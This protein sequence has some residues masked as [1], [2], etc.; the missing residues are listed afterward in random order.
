MKD[1]T[2]CLIREDAKNGRMTFTLPIPE[3]VLLNKSIHR[4]VTRICG[5]G[6]VVAVRVTKRTGL[7][8]VCNENGVDAWEMELGLLGD[9]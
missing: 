9:A 7:L 3:D 4:R 5:R 2:T 6:A 8:C 1:D